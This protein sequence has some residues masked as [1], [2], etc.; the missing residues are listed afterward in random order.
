MK[1]H[2][3]KAK[4]MSYKELFTSNNVINLCFNIEFLRV[5]KAFK[6]HFAFICIC[7]LYYFLVSAQ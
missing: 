4:Q 5:S 1:V 7:T 6:I 2:Q 3:D